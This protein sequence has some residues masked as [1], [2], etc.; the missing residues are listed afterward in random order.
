MH[1]PTFKMPNFTQV[2]HLNQQG[3]YAFCIHLKYA[4][5]YIPIVNCHCHFAV[6]VTV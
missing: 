2:W 3:D 5:L 4:Y 1:I 6:C